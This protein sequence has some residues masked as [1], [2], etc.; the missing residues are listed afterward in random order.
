MKLTPKLL[1]GAFEYKTISTRDFAK[2]GGEIPQNTVAMI[3]ESEAVTI[4]V[5]TDKTD[6]E[7]WA[8]IVNTN[9]TSLTATGITAAFSETLAKAN[10]PCNVIAA[11]YHD[12]I[13]VPYSMKDKAVEILKNVEIQ[14]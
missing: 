14:G 10:I 7:I 5:P 11:Y 12:H 4:I 13:L 3:K 2:I 9:I 1:D 8:W 6:G